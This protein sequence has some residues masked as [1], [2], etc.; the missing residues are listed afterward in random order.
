MADMGTYRYLDHVPAIGQESESA[1][2]LDMQAFRME[3][4]KMAAEKTSFADVVH[5]IRAA[6]LLRI[7]VESGVCPAGSRSET[8]N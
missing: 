6:D 5:I 7:Y 8:A 2:D 3:C 4:L 1:S